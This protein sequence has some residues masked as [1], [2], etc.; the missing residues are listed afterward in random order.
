MVAQHIQTSAKLGKANISVDKVPLQFVFG[1]E[2][3]ADKFTEVGHIHVGIHS[4]NFS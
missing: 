1:Q 3:S 4:P 2:Q